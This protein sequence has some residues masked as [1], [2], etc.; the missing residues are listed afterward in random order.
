MSEEKVFRSIK[1]KVFLFAFL[2]VLLTACGR[3]EL[4]GTDA[5]TAVPTDVRP[6]TEQQLREVEKTLDGLSNQI[7]AQASKEILIYGATMLTSYSGVWNE[8][9]VAEAAGHNVTV[10]DASTWASMTQTQFAA[11]NAIV[12]PTV[13]DGGIPSAAEANKG[14]WSPVVTGPVTINTVH[15]AHRTAGGAKLTSSSINFA[16]SGSSTGLYVNIGQNCTIGGFLSEVADVKLGTYHSDPVVITDS[17]SPVVFNV[18]G[19]DLSNWHQSI[20]AI[21][22]SLPSGH[23]V[24]ATSDGY[25][26]LIAKSAPSDSTPPDTSIDMNSPPANP[27]K[28]NSASFTF[29]GTDNVT[30]VGNLRFEC[31][32][33]GAAFAACTS[34]KTYEGLADGEH[35]FEAR[36][37]DAAGNVD[38]TPASH[39]WTVDT[40][41]PVISWSSDINDGD[42]FY[43][44]SV[45]AA[46]SCTASDPG[47]VPCVVGGYSDAVGSHTLNATATD[48][49][50]NTAR[51]TRS[52]TV[53]AWTLS[54]FYSP[55]SSVDG[56]YNSAKA[57]STVPMKF[58]VH[59]G[60]VE[61]TST[62][63]VTSFSATKIT[64]DTGTTEES[65]D[66]VTTGGTSLR[67]DTTDGQ[68]IQNW[69]TPTTAGCYRAT[70]TTLDGSSLKALFRLR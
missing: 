63:A 4:A 10:V 57:G 50:G 69:Q 8:K 44:G 36:A 67:Y 43:Y 21:F 40:A 32:L 19:S 54:G 42:S 46:P 39:T 58:E 5:T 18:T 60:S 34:P 33:D 16:A 9:T 66:F 15:M 56:V 55:L 12:V 35:A 3:P 30:P 24:I 45:P 2:L 29:S 51:E 6:P 65:V 38:A 53:L 49:A 41:P 23:R 14:V 37:I 68:F 11:F 22:T 20:H 62:S 7:S 47:D 61:Q 25:P 17:S 27:T 13:C 48:G 64:C 26:V 31:R 52:Y 70:M 28:S 1:L 59:V